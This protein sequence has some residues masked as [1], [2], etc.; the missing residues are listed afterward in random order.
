MKKIINRLLIAFKKINRYEYGFF[1]EGQ[2]ARRDRITGAVQFIL[3]NAGEQG[4]D[5][6][7]WY[8]SD[9]SWWGTFRA[10]K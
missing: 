7:F 6:D 3:W 4:H 2:K 5:K 10:N 1:R 8:N 9:P